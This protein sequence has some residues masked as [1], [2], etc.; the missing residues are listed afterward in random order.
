MTEIHN[1]TDD[2]ALARMLDQTS[3]DSALGQT[4]HEAMPANFETATDELSAAVR[5]SLKPRQISAASEPP[6]PVGKY[7]LDYLLNGSPISESHA[8]V[9]LAL[10]RFDALRRIGITPRTS[11]V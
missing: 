1:P 7:R 4:Q 5:E 6:R 2:N 3:D 8:T 9:R 11:T 10:A